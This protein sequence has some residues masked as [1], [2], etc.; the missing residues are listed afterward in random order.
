MRRIVV[1]LLVV[2][3][4]CGVAAAQIK[5]PDQIDQRTG[6]E[7]FRLDGGQ[8]AICFAIPTNIPDNNPAGVTTTIDIPCPDSTIEDLDLLLQISHT[9]VGDLT[10]TLSKDGGA[11]VVVLDRPGLQPPLPPPGSCCGCSG[12]DIDATIDDEGATGVEDECAAGTPTI[13]GAFIG[14]DPA[15][16]TLMATWDGSDIC[17]SWALNVSDGAGADTGFITQWCLVPGTDGGGDGAGDGAGDG[18]GDGG[19]VPSTTGIGVIV[20]MLLLLGSSA[21]FLRR[22]ATN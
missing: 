8:D 6:P 10:A 22:K 21:Y 3:L 17:G 20:L 4:G 19:G 11:P 18:G 1:V 12:D 16:N 15:T 9:W 5:D 7:N 13:Q 14:G 2:L